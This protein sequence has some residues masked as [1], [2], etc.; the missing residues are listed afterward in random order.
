MSEASKICK[1]DTKKKSVSSVFLKSIEESLTN[2]CCRIHKSHGEEKV[3]V[4]TSGVY[5]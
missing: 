3:G 2:L 4:G 5:P 1:K